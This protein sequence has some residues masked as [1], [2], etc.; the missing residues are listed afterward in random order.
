MRLRIFVLL[1]GLIVALSPVSVSAANG[2]TLT[3]DELSLV[4]GVLAAGGVFFSSVD[5]LYFIIVGSIDNPNFS[6]ESMDILLDTISAIAL[7]SS[8]AIYSSSTGSFYR[9]IRWTWEEFDM[10]LR[11]FRSVLS[12]FLMNGC[13]I[14]GVFEICCCIGYNGVLVSLAQVNIVLYPTL[15]YQNLAFISNNAETNEFHMIWLENPLDYFGSSSNDILF[16]YDAIEPDPP[17]DNGNNGNNDTGGSSWILD[18]LLD[19]LRG[20]IS[21]LLD[22]LVGLFVPSEDFWE[23]HFDRISTEMMEKF[24]YYRYIQLIENLLDV[25]DSHDGLFAIPDMPDGVHGLYARLHLLDMMRRIS[26]Y[27]SPFRVLITGMYAI[28]IAH[29]NYRQFYF[30]IRGT[31]YAGIGQTIENSQLRD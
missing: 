15:I 6:H 2:R 28:F 30:M 5:D 9:Y 20:I 7:D 14:T 1:M 27:L 26:P 17:P 10:I 13:D 23:Y 25:S 22:G 12:M 8:R 18:D 11:Y 24:P 19:G 4:A 29:Y 21:Y 31:T 3:Q 16:P